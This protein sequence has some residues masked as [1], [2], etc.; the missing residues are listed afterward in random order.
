MF[1][2][3]WQS[4]GYCIFANAIGFEVNKKDTTVTT[5]NLDYTATGEVTEI[6]PSTITYSGGKFTIPL[7]FTD[8]FTFK[9]GGTSKTATYS[10][11]TFTWTIA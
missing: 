9:D 5:V 2:H 11:E 3:H 6:N 10:T 1:L 8:N 4:L 7:S